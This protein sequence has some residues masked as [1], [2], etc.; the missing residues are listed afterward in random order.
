[1]MMNEKR[2]LRAVFHTEMPGQDHV[3]VTHISEVN[4]QCHIG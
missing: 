1:M 3:R 4:V 2:P